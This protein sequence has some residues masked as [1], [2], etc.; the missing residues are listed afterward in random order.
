MTE[1]KT[2]TLYAKLAEAI[3]DVERIGKD[4]TNEHFKYKYTSAEEVYRVIRQ[5]LLSRGLLVIPSVE[6]IATAGNSTTLKLLLRIIDSESGEVLTAHWVGEG[7]DPGDKGPPKAATGGMKTWLRHLFMLP[8]DDDPEADSSTDSPGTKQAP[9]KP[10]TKQ[11][12][13]LENLAKEAGFMDAELSVLMAWAGA[14]LTGGKEGSCSA[15]INGLKE[16]DQ[17]KR[18]ETVDRLGRASKDW[19]KKQSDLPPPVEDF[20][21]D[22]E[23][24]F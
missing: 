17:A 23:I 11:L 16:K 19:A 14:E 22:Q 18:T 7:Q 15:A 9:G 21:E 3:G 5:P 24:D 1:A 13:F 6:D 8:A 2:G 20:P 10:S 12:G 4:G